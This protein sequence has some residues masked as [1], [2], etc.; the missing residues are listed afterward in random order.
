M[1][2]YRVGDVPGTTD[3]F[4][5]PEDVD[6]TGY[7]GATGV[8]YAPDGT[9]VT[10]TGASFT[11]GYEDAEYDT[12]PSE[13]AVTV[14]WGTVTPFVS[15]VGLYQLAVKLTGAG[16]VVQS[17]PYFPI[18]VEKEDGW[19][20]IASLRRNWRDAPTDDEDC[21]EL[22]GLS[23]A[24]VIAFAPVLNFTTVPVPANYRKAQRMQARNTWNAAKVDPSNGSLGDDTFVI[25]PYPL[26]WSIKQILRPKP[27]IGFVG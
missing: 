24:A 27:A 6:V 26:D 3:V 25:R 10:L 16:T 7:T 17:L 12:E 8:L 20:T 21:F 14:N 5:V 4:E 23:K 22:L 9:T 1:T 19:L 18:V 11:L 2:A 13:S 15:Q